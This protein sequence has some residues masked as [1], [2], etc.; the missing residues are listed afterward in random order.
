MNGLREIGAVSI[1]VPLKDSPQATAALR[2]GHWDYTHDPMVMRGK[3][4]RRWV[5]FI[6]SGPASGI[7]SLVYALDKVGS[8]KLLPRAYGVAE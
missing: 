1:T 6:A 4:G 2:A 3:W 5:N 7:E 8:V